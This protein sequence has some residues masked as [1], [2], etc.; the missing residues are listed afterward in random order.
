MEFKP[1]VEKENP[2]FKRKEIEGT[3]SAEV[4]PK[5]EDVTQMLSEKYSV[6]VE[7]IVV[8]TID[9]RFGAKEF[10]IVAQLYESKEAKDSTGSENKEEPKQEETKGDQKTSEPKQE[11][12]TEEPP[13]PEK[14]P[15][16]KT[17][18]PKKPEATKTLESKKIKPEPKPSPEK[19][20]E[21]KVETPKPVPTT[22]TRKQEK[23]KTQSP[24]RKSLLSRFKK[25]K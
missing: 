4:T 23:P 11:E 21:P 10:I 15:E 24:P 20:P 2:L 3:I 5:R 13:T 22:T 14:K 16:E 8:D 9:G 6:P 17:E 1:V 25:S 19:K 12:K 7:N 18:E